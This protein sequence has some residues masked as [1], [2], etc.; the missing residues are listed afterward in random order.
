M[1]QRS[2]FA[3]VVLMALVGLVSCSVLL[4]AP[5]A[6]WASTRTASD[7]VVSVNW[8]ATADYSPTVWYASGRPS[9]G[10]QFRLAVNCNGSLLV[11]LAGAQHATDDA[12]EV[13]QA[14]GCAG[15]VSVVILQ[16]RLYTT[17]TLYTNLTTFTNPAASPSPSPSVSPSVSPSALDSSLF[18]DPQLALYPLSSPSPAVTGSPSRAL[19][20]QRVWSGGVADPAP[21]SAVLSCLSDSSPA[22]SPAPSPSSPSPTPSPSPVSLSG[23]CHVEASITSGQWGVLLVFAGTFLVLA[24]TAWTRREGRAL[25]Y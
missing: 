14:K 16:G 2:L 8:T 17:E 11:G 6:V 4:L 5:G 20:Y 19:C 12:S 9:S 22:P 7:H 24:L 1:S 18:C 13:L 10:R 15:Y 3:R 23:R 25:R 21:P